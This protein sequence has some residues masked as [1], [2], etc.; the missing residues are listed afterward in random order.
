LQKR[1]G[2]RAKASEATGQT[3]VGEKAEAGK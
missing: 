3:K 2:K 1:Y